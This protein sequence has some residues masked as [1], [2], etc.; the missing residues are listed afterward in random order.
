MP[1]DAFEFRNDAMAKVSA[2]PTAFRARLAA[3]L[4]PLLAAACQ[5]L[6]PGDSAVL[7]EALPAAAVLPADAARYVV[8]R[9]ASEV[10]LLVYRDGPLARFG[11]NHVIVGRAEGEVRAGGSAAESGFRL[12]I[13]VESFIV[14]PPQARAEEG[15]GFAAEV[16]APARRATRE[17]MLGP[18][19]LDAER[20]PLVR[21]ESVALAGP[22]WNPTVTA[23]VE[24]R[25]VSRDVRFAAAVFDDEQTLTVIASFRFRHSDFGIAP[26]AALGGGLLVHDAIDLRLRLLARR[27]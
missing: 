2:R 23:R 17:N 25:G 8:D 12:T 9:Q 1:Y 19:V 5:S 7:A 16:S 6:P 18:E 20:F 10:R 14:D 22:P 26:F 21:I 15:A 27:H 11:H 24:L 13:P 4:F 3:T